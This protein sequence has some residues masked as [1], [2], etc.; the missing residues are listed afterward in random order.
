MVADHVAVRGNS[1]HSLADSFEH[2]RTFQYSIHPVH[3]DYRIDKVSKVKIERM[4]RNT[5]SLIIMLHAMK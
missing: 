2:D 3:N 5:Q 4:Q 1:R